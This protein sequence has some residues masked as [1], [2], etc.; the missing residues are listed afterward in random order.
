MTNDEIADKEFSALTDEQLERYE[1]LYPHVAIVI[2]A[3]RNTRA[4]LAEIRAVV[5]EQAN[6]PALWHVLTDLP[7]SKPYLQQELRRLHAEVEK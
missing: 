1:T 3:L 5:D 7:L 2:R 4:K 6:D